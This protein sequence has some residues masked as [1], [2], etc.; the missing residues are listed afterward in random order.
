MKNPTKLRIL[1]I[2][3]I[4]ISSLGILFSLIGITAMW[5]VR[6]RIYE[7]SITLIGSMDE[8][9]DTT[10]EVLSILNSILE[11][12]KTTL[13]T[14][15][16]TFTGLEDTIESTS[17]SLDSSASLVGDDLR[18]TLLET[19]TALSS[20]ASS[21]ELIDNTLSILASIPL[22]GAD[23][24]P[25]VPLHISLSQVASSLEDIPESLEDFEQNLTDTAQGLDTL[26]ENLSE[27]TENIDEFS[28]DLEDAQQVLIDYRQIIEMTKQRNANL[29]NNL[30]LYLI[31]FMLFMSGILFWLGFTQVTILMQGIN[32]FKGEQIV[33]NLADI[34]RE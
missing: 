2:A 6:P 31:L 34:R 4:I 9:L 14:I 32:Y 17:S 19:Q 11:N 16:E 20:A 21:A 7:A 22:I 29:R 23:Y 15:E 30:S 3:F 26:N 28:G 8:S 5:V 13:A 25:D 1:G 24:Q 27:I 10:D 18:L 33:V 12:S